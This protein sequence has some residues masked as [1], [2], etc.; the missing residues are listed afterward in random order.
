MSDIVFQQAS[1]TKVRYRWWATALIPATNKA[2]AD[3]GYRFFDT[4]DLL[5][6]VDF[7]KVP[8]ADSD[9]YPVESGLSIRETRFEVYPGDEINTLLTINNLPDFLPGSHSFF[10]PVNFPDWLTLENGRL[11]GRFPSDEPEKTY[12][13]RVGLRWR[14]KVVDLNADRNTQY[15]DI[16]VRLRFNKISIPVYK[17]ITI[18]SSPYISAPNRKYYT[19]SPIKADFNTPSDRPLSVTYNG[20]KSAPTDAGTYTVVVE[21][22]KTNKYPAA[23]F[24][25]QFKILP[26]KPLIRVSLPISRM[27]LSSPAVVTILNDD[28]EETQIPFEIK[29]DGKAS[30]SYPMR[31]KIVVDV[32]ETKNNS[33]AKFSKTFDLDADVDS[34]LTPTKLP[35]IVPGQV[36]EVDPNEYFVAPLYVEGVIDKFNYKLPS[37]LGLKYLDKPPFNSNNPNQLI[38]PRKKSFLPDPVSF[39]IDKY[40]IYA[41]SNRPKSIY[42]LAMSWAFP[43]RRHE[44]PPPI[45]S[46]LAEF[47]L[48]KFNLLMR[49]RG[50]N[51]WHTLGSIKSA[52]LFYY[53]PDAIPATE[54]LE[55]RPG[56]AY[57]SAYIHGFP[58]P[59]VNLPGWEASDPYSEDL[60]LVYDRMSPNG[61]AV[62]QEA[63]LEIRELMAPYL[64]TIVKMRGSPMVKDLI[65][66]EIS[67]SN[68]PWT[69]FE[70]GAGFAGLEDH[71]L[72]KHRVVGVEGVFPPSPTMFIG[73]P[74]K[75][76][77]T[78]SFF[79]LESDDPD[80]YTPWPDLLALKASFIQNSES[81]DFPAKPIMP[82]I[83]GQI[84]SG[85]RHIVNL[86]LE[87]QAGKA[88]GTF[89]IKTP[90]PVATKIK[91]SNL[92][93]DFNGNALSPDITVTPEVPFK[94]TYNGST[95]PPV[96]AGDYEL[97]VTVDEGATK[98]A[99]GRVVLHS[100]ARFKGT[101]KILKANPK[102]T[103]TKTRIYTAPNQDYSIPYT[104]NVESA[105]PVITYDGK[106][107]ISGKYPGKPG[108]YKVVAQIEGN[109]NWN[110]ARA[111]TDYT[112]LKVSPVVKFVDTY[113]ETTSSEK[114]F[115]DN[116]K[117]EFDGSPKPIR[118]EVVHKSTGGPVSTDVPGYAAEITYNGSPT[119]PSQ[120]G[121]H[122][123]N[124]VVKG[125]K[126]FVEPVMATA[127]LEILPN[128]PVEFL[129]NFDKNKNFFGYLTNFWKVFFGTPG[130]QSYPVGIGSC[131]RIA[132][133]SRAWIWEIP[134]PRNPKNGTNLISGKQWNI[135]ESPDSTYLS[136]HA[137]FGWF[138]GFTPREAEFPVVE[139]PV[140]DPSKGFVSTQTFAYGAGNVVG[141]GII[142]V[143]EAVVFA[144]KAAPGTVTVEDVTVRSDEPAKIPLVKFGGQAADI[145][146]PKNLRALENYGNLNVKIFASVLY[147]NSQTG[148]RSYSAPTVPGVYTV[149]A[150][151]CKIGTDNFPQPPQNFA[152]FATGEYRV[153]GVKQNATINVRP[154]TTVA[155][156]GRPQS[157]GV[158]VSP[159]YL[160]PII[161]YNGSTTAPTT[162]GTY[163]VA[164][165]VPA[166]ES[167]NAT[168]TSATLV[169]TKSSAII[170][171]P[172]TSSQFTGNAQSITVATL[173]A[174]LN[175][176]VT[177]GGVPNT[178][179]TQVG[180]YAVQVTVNDPNYSGTATA[181]FTIT[182]GA[183]RIKPNQVFAYRAGKPISSQL[184]ANDT[185]NRPVTMWQIKSSTP[186]PAG[187]QFNT[188]TGAFSGTINT[189]GTVSLTVVATGPGGR[190]EKAVQFVSSRS[191]VFIGKTPIKSFGGVKKLYFGNNL[192]YP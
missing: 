185:T 105:V 9:Y 31:T 53:A 90:D 175:A 139:D 109:R 190:D 69:E 104:C 178:L 43:K 16:P 188:R 42:F 83:Y 187:L 57:T 114:I 129:E 154:T 191:S 119:P 50:S 133:G 84:E 82:I 126:D 59:T 5:E 153:Q 110:S 155:F 80:R 160:T 25:G 71:D 106:P 125:H 61:E 81:F 13:I 35:K 124:V 163:S 103:F 8:E 79:G 17:K 37:G 118:F 40:A 94:V 192:L 21:A 102:I 22:R 120:P 56:D 143:K 151:A 52:N 116:I 66:S 47:K 27:A 174:G 20:S 182:A 63:S 156:N 117:V 115:S 162:A 36:F 51:A 189:F 89:E 171:F 39:E 173:P 87:N 1:K 75:Y 97:I 3:G 142:K 30:P 32:A 158:E 74:N 167:T 157:V 172:S 159:S 7:P 134:A 176:V 48:E 92:A 6:S 24:E 179:P 112:I 70:H 113:A 123:V 41:N 141:A 45:N 127:K 130:A 58:F 88:S 148:Y 55:R 169:I 78:L 100:A 170:S 166:T 33:S 64:H 138:P 107:A 54:R 95:K 77:Q 46:Q 140:F 67:V 108:T 177:Y 145:Q 168:A 96:N 147:A 91:V 10:N 98:V 183:P 161:T 34:Y 4:P 135:G 65:R 23:R 186:L 121:V 49:F 11:K 2:A 136:Y 122:T 137:R 60:V 180:S 38:G 181:T 86:T 62:P 29:Y 152:G 150:F 68:G 73:I 184:V 146:D 15:E 111:T 19:G 144:E 93:Q 26:A 128:E 72:V 131:K 28:K 165:S 14:W 76:L 101:F 164:V 85:G 99:S 44:F 149:T 12:T 18:V 132:N